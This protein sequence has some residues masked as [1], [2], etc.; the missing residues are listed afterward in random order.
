[1]TIEE[2]LAYRMVEC[3]GCVS[4]RIVTVRIPADLHHSGE[5][6]YERKAIDS[7]VAPIVEALQLYG[8]HMRGSCCGHGKRDGEIILDRSQW[9]NGGGTL[10]L[11][12]KRRT[13]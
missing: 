5:V 7:C 12:R 2:V 11:K 6:R 8:I 1:M 9:F 3:D 4:T 13:G 10:T